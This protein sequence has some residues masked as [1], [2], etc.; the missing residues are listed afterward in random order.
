MVSR[1]MT[2]VLTVKPT[3]TVDKAELYRRLER[4]YSESP[5]DFLARCSL[6]I[7]TH[8]FDELCF[9]FGVELDEDVSE[10]SRRC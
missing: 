9:D 10:S 5:H 4:E 6:D 7:A 8:D 1:P 2:A 3:I